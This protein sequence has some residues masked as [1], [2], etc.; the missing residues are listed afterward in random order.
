METE[1]TAGESVRA[2]TRQAAAE[3]RQSAAAAQQQAQAAK[4]AKQ[5]YEAQLR[6][7]QQQQDDLFFQAQELQRKYQQ[8]QA[9]MKQWMEQKAYEATQQASNTSLPTW[10]EQKINNQASAIDNLTSQLA[11]MRAMFNNMQNQQQQP[12]APLQPPDVVRVN[13]AHVPASAAS[14]PTPIR[15][16]VFGLGAAATIPPSTNGVKYSIPTVIPTEGSPISHDLSGGSILNNS[17]LHGGVSF[18]SNEMDLT[19]S[20]KKKNQ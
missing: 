2:A 19:P 8:E 17:F 9:D 18:D 1:S 20:G 10:A 14:L 3:A 16:A 13:H 15:N 6:G 11:E 4:S 12:P 5:A 7:L